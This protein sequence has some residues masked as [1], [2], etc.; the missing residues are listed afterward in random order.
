M[1]VE[2]SVPALQDLDDIEDYIAKDNY[3]RAVNF[4]DELISLGES[5][6]DDTTCERG[7]QPQWSKNSNIRELYYQK[8]TIVYEIL[9]YKVIIHEVYNQS[10][11]QLHFGSR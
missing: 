11:I 6:E 4:V 5:L 3:N 9:G 10:K 7:T 8:Y 2:W 1:I